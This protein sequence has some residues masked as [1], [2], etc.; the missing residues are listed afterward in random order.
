MK[1]YDQVSTPELSTVTIN[2]LIGKEMPQ[3]NGHYHPDEEEEDVDEGEDD[4]V[5]GDEE[6]LEGDE[7]E[8][9]VDIDEAE[10]PEEDLVLN[11]DEDEEEDEA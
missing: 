9:E 4:L 5:L 1:H 7:E 10:V 3:V 2:E 11:P 6:V 8:Y